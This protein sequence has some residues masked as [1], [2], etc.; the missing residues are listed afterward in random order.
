MARR[1]TTRWRADMLR[2]SSYARSNLSRSRRAGYAEIN[3]GQIL[4]AATSARAESCRESKLSASWRADCH[5]L[6]TTCGDVITTRSPCPR[7][8]RAAGEIDVERSALKICARCATSGT[9]R[10]EIMKVIIAC[11][12]AAFP[13]PACAAAL[14]AGGA[15]MI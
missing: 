4:E 12:C 8:W 7:N 6:P 1:G 9:S 5:R 2:C 15:K 3:R 13:A 11:C 10:R 14:S